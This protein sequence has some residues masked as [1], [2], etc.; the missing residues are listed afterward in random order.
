MVQF[1]VTIHRYNFFTI[2]AACLI[3][4]IWGLILFF[5]KSPMNKPWRISLIVVAALG[6]FQGL[7][8]LTMLLGFGLKAGGGNGLYYLHYVYGAIV[9]LG[10]PIALTYTSN[11]KEEQ[12]AATDKTEKP[13]IATS[14]GIKGERLNILIFSIAALIIAAAAVRAFVTGPA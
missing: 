2:F 10:L 11:G 13:E 12:N 14:S 9:A 7:L 5:R 3:A 1:I 8:G 4:G 6:A